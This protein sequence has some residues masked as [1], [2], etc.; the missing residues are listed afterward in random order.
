MQLW[1]AME[2]CS[3]S[4]VEVTHSSSNIAASVNSDDRHPMNQIAPLAAGLLQV[5]VQLLHVD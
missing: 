4:S 3:L 1:V 5:G 2:R